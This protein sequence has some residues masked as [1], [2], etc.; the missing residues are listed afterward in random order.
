MDLYF[1]CFQNE[2]KNLEDAADE[3]ALADDDGGKIPYL[4]GEV[5]VYQDVENTQVFVIFF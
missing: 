1:I 3:I 2:L 5:F 4:I